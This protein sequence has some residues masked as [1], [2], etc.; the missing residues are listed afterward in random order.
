MQKS[1]NALEITEMG[2]FRRC[3]DLKNKYLDMFRSA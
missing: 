3:L 1:V 2:D